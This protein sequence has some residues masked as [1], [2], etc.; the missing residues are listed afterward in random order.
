MYVTNVRIVNRLNEREVREALLGD[1]RRMGS[2]PKSIHHAAILQ[3]S[4]FFRVDLAHGK[5]ADDKAY[6]L[7]IRRA[8]HVE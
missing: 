7:I 1:F 8:G 5:N 2:E 6:Q 4:E 3:I